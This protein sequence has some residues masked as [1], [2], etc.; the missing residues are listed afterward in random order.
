MSVLISE[1]QQWIVVAV[2]Y[3]AI[4]LL[5]LRSPVVLAI[6]FLTSNLFKAWVV[7][8]LGESLNIDYTIMTV[9]LIV[10]AIVMTM[11]KRNQEAPIAIPVPLLIGY[12]FLTLILII[13]TPY[14]FTWAKRQL[15]QH[16][17]FNT[18]GMLAPLFLIRRQRDLVVLWAGIIFVS[19][20]V[21]ASSLVSPTS[22]GESRGL[23]LASADSIATARMCAIGV[24]TA[25][26]LYP[27]WN[28]LKRFNNRFIAILLILVGLA[29][30][31]NSGS[32]GPLLQLTGTLV[33]MA[34]AP[35][36]LKFSRIAIIASLF[37]AFTSLVMLFP[38][39]PGLDRISTLRQVEQ[40]EDSSSIGYRLNAWNFMLD[41][42]NEAFWFGRG[43]AVLEFQQGIQAHSLVLEILYSGGMFAF[44]GLLIMVFALGWTWFRRPVLAP[45][46]PAEW[47]AMPAFMLAILGLFISTSGYEIVSA[48]FVFFWFS[49]SASAVHLM[50]YSRHKPEDSD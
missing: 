12:G 7:T 41:Y 44:V 49:A 31:I 25:A 23:F 40:F 35:R 18:V 15:F 16:I 38:D 22:Y 45:E 28:Q 39:N 30:L 17:G 9:G 29:G 21:S 1:S 20:L 8:N 32:R 19:L 4:F 27:S 14:E 13:A 5:A 3:A 50:R 33:I 26:A 36:K 34:V 42:W 47:L 11:F 2:F 10:I 37:V 48:R 43:L 46:D 6:P 24:V